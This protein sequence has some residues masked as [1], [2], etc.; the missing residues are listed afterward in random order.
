MSK[1]EPFTDP[2]W[3]NVFTQS[4]YSDF[5]SWW[6]AEANLVEEGNFRGADAH[7]SWSHVSR[8]EPANGKTVYLKRQQNHYPNNSL[9]KALKKTTFEIEWHNYLALK[10]A[11]VPTLKF[12]YFFH[13]KIKGDRQSIL[14]SEE[15]QGMSPINDLIHHFNQHGWP[16]R[17]QRLA[18]VGS[19][20]KIIRKMHDAGIIH[21]ALYGRHIYLNISVPAEGPCIIP[22]DIRACLIDLERAKF[23]GKNSP[24]LIKNDLEKMYRRVLWP[25]RDC[26]W[27]LKQY[28]G[29]S[30]LTPEA[31]KI[32]RQI[33]I[34]RPPQK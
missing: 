25:T 2:A 26:L 34:T 15:L 1:L 20:V 30:K 7:S 12:I 14:V 24:K 6:T 4:G 32:A 22:D 5:D 27:F 19:I 31:K 13:R 23:P 8:I 10:K 17:K 18:I 28:L 16:T 9:L 21:N 3:K 11:G 33:A 29:I